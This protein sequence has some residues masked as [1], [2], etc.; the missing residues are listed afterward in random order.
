MTT[1]IGINGF[2][3]IGRQTLK[4]ILERHPDEL[5]VVAI[6]DLRRRRDERPPVQVRLDLRPL[7]RRGARRR[8]RD[9]RRRP[10][11]PLVQRAGPGRAA[12]GRPR[13]RH[14]RRVDRH[15]H[16]CDEGKRPSRRRRQ[17]GDH[18]RAGQERGRHAS[19]SGVNE[20]R[21]DPEQHHIVSNASCTTNGLALPAKVIF[22]TL[23]HR[24]RPDDDG[25]QLH[26]RPERARR[27]P[28]GPA[29]R[30]QRRTEH[31]PDHDRRGEGAGPR[32]PR[33]EGQVRRL[34]AARA[35]ADGQRHRLRRDH[36]AAGDRRSPP[37]TPCARRPTDR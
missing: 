11:D 31:H 17:E 15:L 27:V 2:G 25:P 6:N 12:V 19:S 16:R 21:Y 32:H 3:R 23:R 4:A 24:A 26:E 9:R 14:R 29:P 36:R 34:L 8:E 13:R 35:D 30:P 7:R 10:R 5:E 1:R 28:Q 20:D 37:T 33:A 22:D 18:H